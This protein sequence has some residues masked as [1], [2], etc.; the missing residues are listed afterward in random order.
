[1][2]LYSY[3]GSASVTPLRRSSTS[4]ILR[5]DNLLLGPRSPPSNAGG[6]HGWRVVPRRSAPM[7]GDRFRPESVID[8]HRNQWPDWIGF[9]DRFAPESVID[10]RR[11]PQPSR[12]MLGRLPNPEK[13]CLHGRPCYTEGLGGF[14]S[15]LPIAYKRRKP[16]DAD[17]TTDARKGRRPECPPAA[18]ALSRAAPPGRLP[19][20]GRTGDPRWSVRLSAARATPLADALVVG[21]HHLP[22]GTRALLPFA[23]RV[24]PR[25]APAR[26]PCRVPPCRRR[27]LPAR[28]EANGRK[29]ANG[30]ATASHLRTAGNS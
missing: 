12:Q 6:S 30:S 1:M 25:S 3:H 29:V 10:L 16:N 15:A 24:V 5:T 23:V 20:L 8:F 19:C 26:G 21:T 28:P 4:R 22:A 11:N 2:A 13:R 18:A 27:G 7:T 17:T 9:T 14:R